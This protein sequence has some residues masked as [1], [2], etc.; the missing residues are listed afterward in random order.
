MRGHC[1][2]TNTLSIHYVY[3]NSLYLMR[4]WWTIS[5]S[6]NKN[7]SSITNTLIVAAYAAIASGILT[8]WIFLYNWTN[9][10]REV[11]PTNFSPDI[12]SNFLQG[13]AKKHLHT[14]QLYA[15]ISCRYLLEAR[16]TL[17]FTSTLALYIIICRLKHEKIV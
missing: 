13:R 10:L 1:Q 9:L 11:E 17:V 7:Q 15:H 5:Q 16:K 6:H 14:A 4:A 12:R 3:D 2:N 8:V